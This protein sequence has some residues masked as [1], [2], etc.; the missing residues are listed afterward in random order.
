M[1]GMIQS[2][3]LSVAAAVCLN[4]ISRQRTSVDPDGCRFAPTEAE[5]KKMVQ[6]LT[7][8]RRSYRTGPLSEESKSRLERTWERII[9]KSNR[10]LKDKICPIEH[11][12]M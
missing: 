12:P 10:G 11:E 1:R 9:N 2:L 8:R 6:S 4:E 7:M 5:Q 3:N